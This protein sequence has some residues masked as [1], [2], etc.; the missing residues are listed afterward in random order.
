VARWEEALDG[1]LD[2]YLYA[3]SDRGRDDTRQFAESVSRRPEMSSLGHRLDER[4]V[5]TAFNAD[6]FWVDPDMQTLWEAAAPT[7]Q[8]EP[9]HAH[10]LLTPTGFVWLPRPF[11]WHDLHGRATS[12]RAIAW[13]ETDI[14]Y[15]T[16]DRSTT[17]E[18][19]LRGEVGAADL[20]VKARGITLMTS[21][22]TH[23]TASAT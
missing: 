4:I 9:L 12:I 16:P 20:T 10:D 21:S 2:L 17:P 14:T 1:L 3:N 22:T 19:V 7:F 5:A 18:Q 11:M 23:L 6:P 15:I 8:P 13:H